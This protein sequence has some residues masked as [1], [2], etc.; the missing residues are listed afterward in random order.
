M[1]NYWLSVVNK[2]VQCA[3]TLKAISHLGSDVKRGQNLEAE[4]ELWGQDRG[5]G[6][7]PDVEAKAEA[8]NNSEKSTK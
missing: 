5:R 6:Q 2:H 8:K 7:F 3:W 4:A 1:S